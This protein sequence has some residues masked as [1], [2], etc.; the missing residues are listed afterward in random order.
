MHMHKTRNCSKH[1]K[2][3]QLSVELHICSECGDHNI[4]LKSLHRTFVNTTAHVREM[5]TYIYI[6]ISFFFL[7]PYTSLLF[8]THFHAPDFTNLEIF[9]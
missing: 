6:Y 4:S 9:C 5:Y 7:Y 1:T 3:T 8:C 2:K